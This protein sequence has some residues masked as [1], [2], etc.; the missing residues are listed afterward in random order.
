MLGRSPSVVSDSSKRSVKSSGYG[1]QS[2]QAVPQYN[3]LYSPNGSVRNKNLNGDPNGLVQSR[4]RR[5]GAVS[6]AMAANN[7]NVYMQKQGVGSLNGS[8]NQLH[9]KN[10]RSSVNSIGNRSNKAK[11]NGSLSDRSDNSAKRI[12]PHKPMM[13]AAK[14]SKFVMNTRTIQ[15][16]PDQ[17]R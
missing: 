16:N 4:I 5:E 8:R 2:K 1:Q 7:P 6:G 3:R 10:S 14:N 15:R 9:R 17:E 12:E 11:S 13:S